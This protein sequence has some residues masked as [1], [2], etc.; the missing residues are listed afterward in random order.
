MTIERIFDSDCPN[1]GTTRA[2]LRAALDAAGLEPQWT[3][4]ERG[5]GR[6][7]E[8]ARR[9]GSPTVLVNG[10]DVAGAAAATSV[11]P[12]CFAACRLYEGVAGSVS[13]APSAAQLAAAISAVIQ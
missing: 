6:S 11:D 12:Q 5:D 8:Y 13:G 1:A 3:E 4:W 7:P 10:C 2:H 9:Y